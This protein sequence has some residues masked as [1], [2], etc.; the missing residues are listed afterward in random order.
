MPYCLLVWR[1]IVQPIQRW[2]AALIASAGLPR[3]RPK[4]VLDVVGKV[5]SVAAVEEGRT[6]EG[7]RWRPR[8]RSSPGPRGAG[9]LVHRAPKPQ[10][11]FWV[12]GSGAGRGVHLGLLAG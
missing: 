9:V 10:A 7:L 5:A 12:A 3:L 11:S 6:V 1:P 2:V 8:W 4:P